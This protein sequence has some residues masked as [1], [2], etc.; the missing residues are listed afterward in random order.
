VA[1]TRVVHH[2]VDGQENGLDD[3]GLDNLDIDEDEDQFQPEEKSSLRRST[4]MA[5]EK[6]AKEKESKKGN[7]DNMV[8]AADLAKEFK[9]TGRQLRIY[10]RG[11]K[12][13]RSQGRWAWEKDSKELASLRKELAA[14]KSEKKEPKAKAAEAEDE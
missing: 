13:K 3:L 4:V 10:L 6:K 14:R 7:S 1:K 12:Y 11:K 2:L 9:T 8:S 5:A